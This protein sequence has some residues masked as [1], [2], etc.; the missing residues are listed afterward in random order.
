[1]LR[2]EFLIAVA[3]IAFTAGCASAPPNLPACTATNSPNSICGLMNPEDL[4]H[5]P[6]R[7]WVVVSQMASVDREAEFGAPPTRPGNLLAV[8]VADGTRQTIYPAAVGWELQ[9]SG[10][11][12]RAGWG[13]PECPGAPTP[14]EFR[15]HGIDVGRHGSG[16]AMLAVVN[17][18]GREAVE[19]FEIRERERPEIEWRGCV[20]M[21][22][23]VSAND[24][25]LFAD[26][27]FVVTKMTPSIES[28]GARAIWTFLKIQWGWDTGAVYR[29]APGGEVTEIPGSEGSAPNG[30]AISRDETEIFVAQWGEANVYRV[31]LVEDASKMRREKARMHHHPDNLTWTDDGRLLAAGQDGSV[32]Q[33][34][35]CGGI[36]RGGCGLDYGVYSIDPDTFEVDLLFTGKGAASVAL[37]VGDDVFVGAFSGDQVERVSRPR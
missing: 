35:E 18:G 37:E 1:M 6:G 12:P 21:P 13:D 17:H 31:S 7:E 27:G 36:E 11:L 10:A 5:L 16:A 32:S 23:D 14:E 33:I 2:N 22:E 4:S 15:P 29:W 8:R 9:P 24:I 34:L 26:G 28:I 19:F 25:A 20:E 3:A 30:V